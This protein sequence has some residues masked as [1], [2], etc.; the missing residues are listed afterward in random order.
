M[1]SRAERADRFLTC[2]HRSAGLRCEALESYGDH[3]GSGDPAMLHARNHLL[4]DE[5]ALGKIDPAELVHVGLVRKRIAIAEIEPAARDCERNAMRL[6][7]GRIGQ[8]RAN[9]GCR[10]AD[11]M[12]REHAAAA[13]FGQ[14]WVSV[15]QAVFPPACP[16]PDGHDAEHIGEILD[17]HLC[18]QLV[19]VEARNERGRERA[20]T[21]EE[22]AAALGGFG[23]RYNKVSDDFP[24]RGQQRSESSVPGI[25][26]S[27]VARDQPIEKFARVIAR[28][29]DDAALGKQRCLH[30]RNLPERSCST[31]GG[32]AGVG[33]SA[34]SR[35]PTRSLQRVGSRCA[36]PNLLPGQEHRKLAVANAQRKA[37]GKARCRLL[38]I[39]RDKFRKGGKQTGLRQTVPI[40]AVD[41]RFLPGFVQIAERRSFLFMVRSLP[42][43]L[44]HVRRSRVDL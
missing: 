33:S 34:L 16:V 14:A 19:E 22:K 23:L 38:A 36:R 43:R 25:D 11:A 4:A 7:R 26:L 31:Q 27:G 2:A 6:V 1:R 18:A 40:D 20:G 35:D 30:G 9:P 29:L 17:D 41:A 24:L 13:Q 39:G 28:D 10:F 3:A 15:A 42:L 32:R 8:L 12:G 21:V 5:A 44:G 37:F